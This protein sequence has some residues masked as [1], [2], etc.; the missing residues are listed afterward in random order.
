MVLPALDVVHASR[1]GQSAQASRKWAVLARYRVEGHGGSVAR[2]QATVP[3]PRSMT[4]RSFGENASWRRGRLCLQR[5]FDA[6]VLQVG[7]RLPGAVG[8]VAP[9]GVL[10]YTTASPGRTPAFW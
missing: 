10:V 6:V 8:G 4:K 3:A 5:G 2:R 1:R 7:Q 9:A